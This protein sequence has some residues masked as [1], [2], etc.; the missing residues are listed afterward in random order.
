MSLIS[1]KP[2]TWKGMTLRNIHTGW[3]YV[4]EYALLSHVMLKS[5]VNDSR[6]FWDYRNIRKHFVELPPG[7]DRLLRRGK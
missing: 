2:K 4:V 3:T 1:D 6:L 5:T 7:G